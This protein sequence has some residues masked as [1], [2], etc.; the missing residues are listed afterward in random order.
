[1]VVGRVRVVDAAQEIGIAARRVMVEWCCVVDGAAALFG[2]QN[3]FPAPRWDREDISYD[4][5]LVAGS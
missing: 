5:P 2:P 4:R 1:M 3:G